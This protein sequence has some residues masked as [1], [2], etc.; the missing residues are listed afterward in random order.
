MTNYFLPA[1]R[2]GA[3]NLSF[4]LRPKGGYPG[5]HTTVWAGD[6]NDEADQYADIQIGER[7]RIRRRQLGMS[8]TD[9]AE[10][11]GVSF[12]QVQKYENGTNRVSA[13][14][15]P[16]LAG[17]L[18]VQ[19]GYFYAMTTPPRAW[20]QR[21]SPAASGRWRSV[22]PSSCWNTFKG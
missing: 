10:R 8:Q 15:L 22:T 6:D 18:D 17:A 14:R 11:L 4:Y 16:H 19:V 9:L 2:L 20:T 3:M 12:Q 7:I 5:S 1:R 13:G 21:S